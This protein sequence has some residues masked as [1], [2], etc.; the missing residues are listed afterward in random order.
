MLV[1]GFILF[2]VNPEPVEFKYKVD[3]VIKHASRPLS[4]PKRFGDRGTNLISPI[5]ENLY[6]HLIVLRQTNGDIEVPYYVS[7]YV[8]TVSFL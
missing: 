1:E 5:Y 6:F 7:Y 2:D 8:R 4:K 3:T